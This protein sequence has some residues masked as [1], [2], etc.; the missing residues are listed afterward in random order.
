MASSSRG[1]ASA[2]L[3]RPLSEVEVTSGQWS[4]HVGQNPKGMTPLTPLALKRSGAIRVPHSTSDVTQRGRAV[5][6]R[7]RAADEGNQWVEIRWAA[8]TRLLNSV[9]SF[10]AKKEECDRLA[11]GAPDTQRTQISWRRPGNPFPMNLIGEHL[12]SAPFFIEDR[13][14]GFGQFQTQQ[15]KPDP[16]PHSYPPIVRNDGPHN[17]SEDLKSLTN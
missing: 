1:G 8:R 4:G 10:I 11:A 12:W 6:A 15:H 9:S 7:A 5:L 13:R 17:G 3:V 16:S 2:P 14:R